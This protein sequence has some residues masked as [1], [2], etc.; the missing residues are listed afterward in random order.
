MNSRRTFLY[1]SAA[2]AALVSAPWVARAQGAKPVKVGILHP[3][4]GALA[5]SGQQCR[6]GALLAIEDINK[7][8]GIKSLGGAPLEAVLGDAQSRPEAGSAEVEK[9][10]EAG[11]SA[12]VG[13]YASAICLA[14]TQTAAKYNLPH[15]VD[16]GVADQIV[17]RGLKNTFRFG[18]GYRACSERA[19]TD[20]AALNDAAGK[21]AKT[22]MI[23][24][25]DSLFGTGTAALLSK[26]LPQH[27]FEIKDVVK[28]PNPTRDFNNI[29]LR[30]KSLNPDI[31]IP[32]NY[33][34]EYALLLRAMKQQKVQPKAIYSVL[35]GAAS[36]YKFLKEFPDI[37][38]G[39]IDCNHWFNPKDAR[40]APLKARVEEKG[41]Y[42][43]YE[44][45]M[46]YTSVLL[47]A[48]ALERAKS[49]DR[50][51][52]IEALA[53]STFSDNIMPYGPTKFVNGQNTGA[54]PLLTQ[55]IGG[56]IKVVIP[57]DYRQADPI[58]PLKA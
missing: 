53:S 5:Y 4:T 1:Q 45:F 13:A 22:V 50:A 19:I 11:V 23:V 28:H 42:F 41:A 32:A 40:V 7:A 27:G 31:V 8:G 39:I 52:I 47:L 44:V 12:I 38:N 35:G 49:A 9:M 20:L 14:T 34:N 54:Q 2:A 6:L 21:P 30:M 55:V 16:V 18:P 58:F 57:A 17:E 46:T 56:D 29:V 24:H 10:N 43:S 15:V 51:A 25:E 37:A 3:V 33:Y 48:D 26:S 36:S